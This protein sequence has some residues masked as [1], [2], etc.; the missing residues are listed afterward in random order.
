MNIE[1]IAQNAIKIKN[2]EGKIIYFDPFKLEE[3]IEQADII[4]ITHSH[5][6]H[7]SPEDIMKIK[8]EDT[9]IESLDDLFDEEPDEEKETEKVVNNEKPVDNTEETYDIQKE[10]EAKFDELFGAFDDEDWCNE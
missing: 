1:L 8:K 4:F 6:D 3:N 7:F 9:K 5:Y 2:K 10:L